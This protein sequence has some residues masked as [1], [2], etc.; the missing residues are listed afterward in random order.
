MILC[1]PVSVMVRVEPHFRQTYHIGV[2]YHRNIKEERLMKNARQT[3]QFAT[4]LFQKERKGLDL[5]KNGRFLCLEGVG[6][7]IY[8]CESVAP[9]IV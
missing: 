7:C 8:I 2:F 3:S 4:S 5:N 1:S 6:G 9:L